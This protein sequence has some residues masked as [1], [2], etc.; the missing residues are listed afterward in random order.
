[1]RP[2]DADFYVSRAQYQTDL[3]NTSQAIADLKRA[4]QLYSDVRDRLAVQ[5]TLHLTQ[6]EREEAF[7]CMKQAARLGHK[8]SQLSLNEMGIQW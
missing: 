2:S 3:G 7:E 8:V 1:L 4:L 5:A 6:G